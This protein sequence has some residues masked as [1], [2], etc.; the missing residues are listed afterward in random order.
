ML[1]AGVDVALDGEAGGASGGDDEQPR[2]GPRALGLDG[3]ADEW[4]VLPLC[5]GVCLGWRGAI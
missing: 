5:G 2:A 3:W 1:L 4:L